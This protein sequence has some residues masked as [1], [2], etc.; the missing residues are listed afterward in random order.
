MG[1]TIEH[2]VTFEYINLEKGLIMELYTDP[3]FPME[4]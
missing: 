3:L 1:E 4:G 2:K